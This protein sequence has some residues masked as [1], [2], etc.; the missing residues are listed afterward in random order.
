MPDILTAVT[1]EEEK[2]AAAGA[3]RLAR[4]EAEARKGNPALYDLQGNY[5]YWLDWL[6]RDRSGAVEKTL[7]NLC[8]VPETDPKLANIESVPEA[9]PEGNCLSQAL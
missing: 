4:H 8:V 1:A 3:R 9:K 6:S 5:V 2:E 7:S